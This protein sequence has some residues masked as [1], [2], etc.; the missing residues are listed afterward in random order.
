MVRSIALLLCSSAFLVGLSSA[1]LS[2]DSDY[3]K[4]LQ[5]KRQIEQMTGGKGEAAPEPAQAAPASNALHLDAP[6]RKAGWWEFA[7]VT[8]SGTAIGKQNL[9]I[10]EASEK[11]IL[12]STRSPARQ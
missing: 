12:P 3:S 8:Q 5:Q 10:D 9:C 7:A 6:M 1:A 4:A 2:A 11:V